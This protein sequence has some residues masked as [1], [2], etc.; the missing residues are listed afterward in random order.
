MTL[1]KVPGTQDPAEHR[2][3]TVGLV[4]SRLYHKVVASR[5]E[6]LCPPDIRQKAFRTGDCIAENLKL[7]K[8]MLKTAQDNHH[9]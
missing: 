4:L 1:L 5:L 6:S 3:I 9:P 7:F 8:A 2:P